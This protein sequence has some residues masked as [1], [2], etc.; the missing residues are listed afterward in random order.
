MQCFLCLP[1]YPRQPKSIHP[2]IH[3]RF[4]TNPTT[5][6]R[7]PLAV[8]ESQ[9]PLL[10]GPPKRPFLLCQMAREN[11]RQELPEW[12]VGPSPCAVTK[13]GG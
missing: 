12:I 1:N 11:D 3:Q 13:E 6:A 10:K 2:H 4:P 9:E 5:R 7:L 8:A